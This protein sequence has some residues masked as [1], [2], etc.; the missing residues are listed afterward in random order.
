MIYNAQFSLIFSFF[1][2]FAIGRTEVTSRVEEVPIDDTMLS[3][4]CP[5]TESAFCFPQKYRT[6]NG[7]CNNVKKPMWGVTGAAYLRLQEPEYEDGVGTPRLMSREGDKLPDALAVS[8]QLMWTHND[9]HEFITALAAI[10]GQFVA[11]DIR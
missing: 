5:D 1:Y 2:S 11:N 4:I 6:P 7:E 3:E 10:W 8:S 9:P